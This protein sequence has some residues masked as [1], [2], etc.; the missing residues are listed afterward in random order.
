MKKLSFLIIFLFFS[1]VL[2]F[3]QIAV[4][5]DGANPDN[6]AMLDIQSDIGGFLL[7]RMTEAQRNGIS[8]PAEGLMVYCTDCAYDNSGIISVFV[9]GHWRLIYTRCTLPQAPVAGVHVTGAS[10]IIWNWNT[11][12][13]ATGYKWNTINDY[14]SAT[15]MLTSTT[16]TE[17]ELGP[18]IYTRFVWAYNA[19]GVSAF[20]AL[21]K[22]LPFAIG[23]EY[24]GGII[25]YLDG[26]G[27]H[28]LIAYPV[29]LGVFEWG[30][31]GYWDGWVV[32]AIYWGIGMGQTNT[33]IIVN[34]CGTP[35]I[36]A[37]VCDNF[38]ADGYDDWFLPSMS[39]LQLMRQLSSVIGGF[40]NGQPYWSSTEFSY[41]AAYGYYWISGTDPQT[42]SKYQGKFVRAIRDF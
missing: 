28:G 2:L 14:A 21:S 42:F 26:T 39:E 3:S 24:G 18:G 33:T 30:C 7:P 6:S 23:Q 12:T 40:V 22:T 4:N 8:G 32:G 34:G 5:N 31:G 1:S 35:N 36:A 41:S 10:Q 9:N 38:V 27:Q 19:C 11:V 25:F 15:D 29:D 17:T 37:R 13:G 16:Y 20:T